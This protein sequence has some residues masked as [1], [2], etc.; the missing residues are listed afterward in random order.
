MDMATMFPYPS[1]HN[2]LLQWK[3]VLCCCEKY[4]GIS[5]PCQKTNKYAT[6]MCSKIGYHVYHNVSRCTFHGMRSYEEQT[7]CS[8]CYNDL[9]SITSE[10]VYNQ[11]EIV[12]LD[13][14]IS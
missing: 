12:L 9:I 6:N 13:N 2:E 11:K 3:C 4:P 5:I 7:I 10:K 1:Q 8:K 14:L